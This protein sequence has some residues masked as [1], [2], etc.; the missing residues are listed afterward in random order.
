MAYRIPQPSDQTAL[1]VP[2]GMMFNRAAQ[3]PMQQSSFAP[4]GRSIVAGDQP[5]MDLGAFGRI[6]DLAPPPSAMSND[7]EQFALGHEITNAQV[8]KPGAFGKGGI[9]WQLLG[10]LGD[11]L[12]A[13][14]SNPGAQALAQNNFAMRRATMQRQQQLEDDDRQQR[15]QRDEWI[16]RQIWTRDHPAPVAPSEFER[17]LEAAG[18][19]RGSPQW[20]SAMQAKV[21]NTTDPMMTTPLQ[22]GGVYVGPRSQFADTVAGSVQ[23]A[24]PPRAPVGKLTPIGGATP[25]RSGTFPLR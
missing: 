12:L 18:V 25:T 8:R 24:A 5:P 14:S 15:Q 16:Q 21:Q 3:P 19:Q 17:T 13:M 20:V 6:P 1:Q 7:S 11:S 23:G 2:G 22:G 10:S 4:G 9:G